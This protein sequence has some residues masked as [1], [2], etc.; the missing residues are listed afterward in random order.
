MK[1]AIVSLGKR[2]LVDSTTTNE[3]LGEMLNAAYQEIVN[4]YQ[5]ER[6][7]NYSLNANRHSPQLKTVIDIA[8]TR[9]SIG[10]LFKL[11]GGIP[12]LWDTSQR[13]NLRPALLQGQMPDL[14]V[15]VVEFVKNE[16]EKL[17]VVIYFKTESL[18]LLDSIGDRLLLAFPNTT[19]EKDDE[20]TY[21]D[22]TFFLNLSDDIYFNEYKLL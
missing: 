10:S 11:R 12:D 13:I 5:L 14:T 15:E 3:I 21:F 6:I 19:G 7:Y 1:K 17:Q 18:V 2:L 4:E 8:V 9:G 22:N 20:Q 16:K